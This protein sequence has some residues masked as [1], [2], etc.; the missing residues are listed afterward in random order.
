MRRLIDLLIAIPCLILSAPF[1][2]L[3][4]LLIKAGSPGPVFYTP[5]MVG[6]FG[7]PFHLYRL[8]TMRSPAFAGQTPE[9][10]LTRVGRFLR[11]YSLDHLP[12]LLNLLNGTL[13]L[14]GPRPM[15]PQYVAMQDPVWQTYFSVK[16]GLIN[17]A[18]LQLGK[19]WTPSR[20]TNPRRN[21]E[22]EL[23]YIRSQSMTAD[24]K[25]IADFMKGLLRSRGNIKARGE[26]IQGTKITR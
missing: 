9:Q 26:P 6:R 20:T 19:D 13:T 16:P 24:I 5:V 12:S 7:R 4:S 15:E 11:R 14:A 25:L 1:L 22:L 21:Q 23:E 17:Y 10:R 8:R 18:V 2:L 3:F